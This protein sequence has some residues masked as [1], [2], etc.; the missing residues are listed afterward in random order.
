MRVLFNCST[1][2]VG[3]GVKNAVLFIQNTLNNK[4]SIEW[5]YACSKQVSALLQEIGIALG[6]NFIFFK[7]SPA[8]NK[9]ARKKLYKT[10]LERKIKLVYTM[11][12]PAYLNF[13]AYH[14]QGLS[15]PYITHA[16]WT[17]FRL[18]GNLFQTLSYYLFVGLQFIYSK[19]ADYFIFQSDEARRSF[20]K[21]GGANKSNTHVIAN[22]FDLSLLKENSNHYGLAKK[23]ITDAKVI[24]CPGA[25]YTHKG[26]QFIPHIAHCILKLG[27]DDIKFRLTLPNG[28]LWLRILKLSQKLKVSHLIENIGPYSYSDVVAHYESADIVFVPSLLETFSASYLEAVFFR[29]KLIVADR[30]FSRE[31]CGNYA[32]YCNPKEPQSSARLICETLNKV[33]VNEDLVRGILKKYGNQIDRMS[34]IVDVIKKKYPSLDD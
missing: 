18:R 12:G 20:I 13:P 29:K 6:E 19:R 25:D 32:V 15:N 22:A 30:S 26:F 3:G 28:E 4:D 9:A 11:A 31:V 16:D 7:E 1:N 34:K 24:F 14:I 2:V 10:C 23:A 17:A 5:T 33:T 27:R 21:R 8:R